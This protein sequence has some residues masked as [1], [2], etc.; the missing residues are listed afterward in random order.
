[1]KK[2]CFLQECRSDQV[3][4][5]LAKGREPDEDGSGNIRHRS[6][7]MAQIPKKSQIQGVPGDGGVTSQ[8]GDR[9]DGQ[10]YYLPF[11]TRRVISSNCGID[12]LNI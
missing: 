1:M 6:A 8:V 2:K 9:E 10:G 5:P 12:S 7:L 3:D 11:M 4:K